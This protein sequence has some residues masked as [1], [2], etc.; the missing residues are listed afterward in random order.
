MQNEALIALAVMSTTVD[1]A[2]FCPFHSLSSVVGFLT[3][4]LRILEPSVANYFRSPIK[5][6]ELQSEEVYSQ[7]IFSRSFLLLTLALQYKRFL[8]LEYV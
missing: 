3:L 2:N 8:A 5:F 4:S 6:Q 7:R 1:G